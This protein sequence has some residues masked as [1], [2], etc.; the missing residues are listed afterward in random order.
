MTALATSFQQPDTVSFYNVV[1]FIHIAA[2]IIAFGVTFAYPM[3]DVLVHKPANRRHLAWWHS[4]QVELGRKL[5][6]IAGAVVLLAG[7]YLAATGVF[8]FKSTFVTI[9]LV[10]IIVILG[11]GGAFF[12]PNERKLAELSARDI[13]AAGEGAEIQLSAEY[14]A[15]AGRVRIVGIGVNVLILIALF[16]MVMKPS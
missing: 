6:T 12:A 1:I 2:A 3:I 7:I 10:I 14:E 13:A 15:V 8:D 11:L 9:G 5:I 4:V 16:V